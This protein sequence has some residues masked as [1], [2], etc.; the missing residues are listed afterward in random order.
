[1]I[2]TLRGAGEIYFDSVTMFIFFLLAGRFVEM[3][4]RQRKLSATE[5][6]ARSL[7]AL[8]TR[9]TAEGLTERIAP[10][11]IEPGDLLSIPKGAVVPV[12]GNTSRG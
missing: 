7:P 12:D 10:R 3:T 4:V 11:V 5:A 2:N 8:V 9:I 6:F 1:M